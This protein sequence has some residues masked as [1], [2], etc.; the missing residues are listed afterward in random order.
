MTPPGV[1]RRMSLLDRYL[2]LWIGVAMVAGIVLGSLWPEAVAAWNNATSV[3]TT[4][5]PIA[6]GLILM[7]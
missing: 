4:S 6:V 3:G 2:T 1:A 5:L 7:M